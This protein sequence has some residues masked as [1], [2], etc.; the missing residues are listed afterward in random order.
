MITLGITLTRHTCSQQ[1]NGMCSTNHWVRGTALNCLLV[2]LFCLVKIKFETMTNHGIVHLVRQSIR[3]FCKR[4]LG[5]IYKFHCRCH[6]SKIQFRSSDV[7]CLAFSYS[8]LE[9]SCRLLFGHPRQLAC[10]W[11]VVVGGRFTWPRRCALNLSP[12]IFWNVQLIVPE[13]Y[14][15]SPLASSRLGIDVVVCPAVAVKD[16]LELLPD[17]CPSTSSCRQLANH[18]LNFTCQSLGLFAVGIEL[19]QHSAVARVGRRL[20][21]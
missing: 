18:G 2:L 10:A 20:H 11:I 16:F 21:G 3:L 4:L 5:V 17:N 15:L 19:K 1:K 7:G 6:C 14:G 13:E 9:H 12:F 8:S